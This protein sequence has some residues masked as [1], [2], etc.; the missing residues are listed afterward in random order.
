MTGTGGGGGG[1]GRGKRLKTRKVSDMKGGING[2][3]NN[4]TVKEKICDIDWSYG[5]VCK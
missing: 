5:L 2:E 1:E 3:N 4:T